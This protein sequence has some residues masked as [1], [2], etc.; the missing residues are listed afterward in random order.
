MDIQMDESTNNTKHI[1]DRNYNA[2]VSAIFIELLTKIMTSFSS[3]NRI[4]FTDIELWT[5]RSLYKVNKIVDDM[6]LDKLKK[7]K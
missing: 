1:E 5:S 6:V 2:E 7:L 3:K 4:S